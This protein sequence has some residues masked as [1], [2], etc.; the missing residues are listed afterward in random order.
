MTPVSTLLLCLPAALVLLACVCGLAGL[1]PPAARPA[2][3]QQE[4]GMRPHGMGRGTRNDDEPV[5][6]QLTRGRRERC[7]TFPRN[8]NAALPV[9]AQKSPL[10]ISSL[11]KNGSQRTP[12]VPS[13]R[14]PSECRSC[15][16]TR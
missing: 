6:W 15:R 2:A 11:K 9:R 12:V 14:A 5:L 1:S 16:R 8:K 7:S 4:P 3:G 13:F 10:T